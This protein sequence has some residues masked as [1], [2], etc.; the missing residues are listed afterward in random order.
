MTAL[1][2]HRPRLLSS[3][4]WRLST[5]ISGLV[6]LCAA[7]CVAGAVIFLNKTLTDRAT[8]DLRNTVNGVQGYMRTQRDDLLGSARLLADD[9]AVQRAVR[10][11]DH[12]ALV[13][14]LLPFYADYL[15]NVDV[16]DVVDAHG[17][18]LVRMEDTL[19]S[20]DSVIGHPSVRAALADRDVVALE[21]DLPQSQPGSGYAYRAT[22]PIRS[23]TRIIG[24]V[25]AGRQLSSI[26]AARIGQALNAQINLIAGGQRTGTTLTDAHGLPTSGLAEP[27]AV[28][29]R[30]ATGTTSIAQE[31]ENGQTVLSGV[32][33]LMDANHHPVGGIEVVSPLNSLYD[34]ITQLSLLLIALG[35]A[36]VGLGT[37]LALA[38]AR[39]LTG[40][41][42]LL[43]G[44]ASHV[45]EAAVAD[46]PLE[47]MH[48][49]LDVSGDDEVASLSR[50]LSAMMTALDQRMI[51]NA[52]L[53][54][55]A[56]ARVRELTGLAEI[57]RLL[58]G[59]SPVRETLDIL[60][61]HVARLLGSPA[62]AILLPDDGSGELL[63]GGYGLPEDYEN[64][65]RALLASA[66][67]TGYEM[68]PLRAMRTGE[69]VW[70]GLDTVPESAPAVVREQRMY[71]G[72][73]GWRGGTSVPLRVQGRTVGVLTCYTSSTVPF[74]D[75]DMSLLNTVADQVAVAVE[76][77]RLYAHSRELAAMEERAR[78]ARELHDS[79]TQA[80][81]SMTLHARTAEL[82]LAR[83]GLD[84]DGPVARAIGQLLELTRGALAEMRALIFELRP[85][86]LG[87][88]GL[89]AALRK[90]AGAVSARERIAIEVEAPPERFGLNPVAEE[91]LYRLSQEAIHN[92]VKHAD[93]SHV[94]IRL[95]GP[96]C[97]D[98]LLEIIDNGSGFD[99]NAVPPGHMGLTTMADRASQVGA[100]LQIISAPGEGT[101]VRVTVATAEKQVARTKQPANS[102]G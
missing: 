82:A 17:T 16:L 39:R 10:K 28:L 89:A 74:S 90:H 60:G 76:N 20:G 57:A 56:Q 77:A 49:A 1:P 36:V 86:A 34:L 13:V 88:E 79:I 41:L 92:V 46:A 93:A 84:H 95:S 59:V 50:S 61:E 83:D 18:V 52:N 80:L 96:D 97:G 4:R 43:E 12:Q 100:S 78:L 32:I 94:L 70:T 45:A 26:Y 31:N 30:V 42:L 62:A 64:L 48:P 47:N 24:A 72:V 38:I 85:G 11:Q 44:T 66:A 51:A 73:Q 5:A 14:H 25:V 71:A 101:T 33:P 65:T 75:L 23:G 9:A 6:L 15:K 2:A 67:E 68:G 3:L 81:F 7:A 29:R 22:V 53:Y 37:L 69:V 27:S 87:E 58:T 99:P 19:A 21:N 98:L 40:R 91:H 35:A 54:E 55:A 102:R 8:Q 63:F